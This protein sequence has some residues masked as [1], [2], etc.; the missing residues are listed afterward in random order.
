MDLKTIRGDVEW[1]KNSFYQFEHEDQISFTSKIQD[2]VPVIKIRDSV[3]AVKGDI[4]VIGGLPKAGKTSCSAFILATALS[5]K[6]LGDTL[7][8]CSSFCDGKMVV[9]IDTEQPRSY[10]NK[11]RLQVCKILG[12]EKEPPNLG[13][14][15]LRKYD[16]QTK[17]EKVIKLM[18]K[19]PDAHLWVIDGIA[20]LIKDPNDTKESF[21]I[22]EKFMMKSDELNTA[23]VLYIHENPG[24]SGKLRGNLG[25][26]AERKGGGVVTIKKIREKGIHSIEAKLIRGGPDFDPVFFRYDI[27]L[28]RMT[29]LDPN[30][31]SVVKAL[32]D[33]ATIKANQRIALAKRCLIT[34]RLNYQDLVNAIISFAMEIEGKPVQKRTAESR[35]KEMKDMG[36]INLNGDFYE[37]ADKYIPQP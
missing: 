11:L 17:V 19:Y 24:T 5:E 35:V 9:Y 22:I 27:S 6:S 28:G 25:S 34:G 18:E 1:H 7:E 23:I 21:G 31:S 16:S 10:T 36:I 30:E 4:S 33:K 12:V 26:E 32:T 29:S 14:V 8:I 15:N 20:D 13:I 2:P 37:L 3:F